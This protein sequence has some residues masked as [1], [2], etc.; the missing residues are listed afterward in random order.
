MNSL[1][2]FENENF[3]RV[4]VILRE[5]DPWFVA[6]DVCE[7]LEIG[8]TSQALTRLRERDVLNLTSSEVREFGLDIDSHANNGMNFI[9]ESGLYD[10]IFLSRKPEAQSFKYWVIDKV[11]PEIR[12]TGSFNMTKQ[13]V[14]QKSIDDPDWAISMLQ[15]FKFE[16]E[17]K[18]LA[19]AQRD[20]AIRTKAHFVEGRDAE[21]CGRVG[22]LTNANERLREKIGFSKNWKQAKAIPWIKKYFDTSIKGFWGQLGKILTSLSNNMNVEV[23]AV[24]DV[25]WGVVNAYNIDVIDKLHEA[26]EEGADILAKYRRWE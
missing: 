20:E 25:S 1:K 10:L 17:Q 13:Q 19:L 21:M 5:N 16:K 18:E 12:K 6:K 2:L 11:L 7:C 22:G 9:S 8:N 15:Q 26:L 24:E 23:R 14:I 3:G 4:R